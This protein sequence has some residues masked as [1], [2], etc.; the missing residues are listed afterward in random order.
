MDIEIIKIKQT[1]EFLYFLAHMRFLQLNKKTNVFYDIKKCLYLAEQEIERFK[2]PLLYNTDNNKII[3]KNVNKS[4]IND[5]TKYCDF[6][7]LNQYLTLLNNGNN[8]L[9]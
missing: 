3:I 4:E 8:Q 1:E 6:K 2:Y 5:I 9:H 7:I